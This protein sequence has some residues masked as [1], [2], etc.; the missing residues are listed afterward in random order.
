LYLR[1]G[2]PERE[3]LARRFPNASK[4]LKD[5][6]AESVRQYFLVEHNE[7]IKDG[8]GVYANASDTEK[9]ICMGKI[10][11]VVAKLKKDIVIYEVEYIDGKNEK[12]IGIYFPDAKIGDYIGIHNN[13]AVEVLNEK[14]FSFGK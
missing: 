4:R 1:G 9:Q 5:W 12:I 7:I 2:S 8:E 3:Y 6:T 10:G 13:S 14:Y 11:R